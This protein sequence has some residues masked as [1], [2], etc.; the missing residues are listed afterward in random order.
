M[1]T[2]NFVSRSLAFAKMQKQTVLV[3]VI[4]FQFSTL[5]IYVKR[6]EINL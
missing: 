3:V 2:L 1:N 5:N 4:Y 6:F